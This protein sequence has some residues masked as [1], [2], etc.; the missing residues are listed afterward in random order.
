MLLSNVRG[1][2]IFG[3]GRGRIQWFAFLFCLPSS[4]YEVFLVAFTA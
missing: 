3:G 2:T 4:E 1:C